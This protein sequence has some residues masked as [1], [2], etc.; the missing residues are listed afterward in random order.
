MDRTNLIFRSTYDNPASVIAPLTS[1]DVNAPYAVVQY[2]V[3]A[4]FR[5]KDAPANETTA[6]DLDAAEWVR[7]EWYW[8]QDFNAK[9]GFGLD[10]NFSAFTILDSISPG[11]AWF[12]EV[13]YI[14]KS[15]SKDNFQFI[16]LM[17]P[18]GV[19]LTGWR[20]NL[21][22]RQG[23]N[24][25]IV[26]LGE[27]KNAKIS[28]KFGTRP[29]IDSTNQFTVISLA[30]PM[31]EG[32]ALFAE[33]EV[34]GYWDKVPRFLATGNLTRSEPYGF[35]LVRPSEV[36]EHQVVVQGTN[37]LAFIGG[38]IANQRSGAA[39][40]ERLNDDDGSGAWFYAGENL[41]PDDQTVG[42][43]RGHGEK[44]WDGGPTWTNDLTATPG[45][46]N[47]RNGQRQFLDDWMLPPNGTNVWIYATVLGD[48][49]W[50]YVDG[51]PANTNRN[52]LLVVSSGAS[53]NIRYVVDS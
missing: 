21:F 8:P 47:L 51:N 46:L 33:G 48:H 11:R 4:E 42:V 15:M 22:D 52:T 25:Y 35:A 2:H 5:R 53:T 7:P 23:T 14:S 6:H 50:Q 37:L 31:A 26:T 29:G 17:V 49:T 27:S 18:E 24:S 39:L 34:D 9:Y 32:S 20:V 40:A 13:N 36:V 41:E 19:D 28:S 12:N 44:L 16:E 1:Q 45:E 43:W 3:W 38:D 30:T 10:D